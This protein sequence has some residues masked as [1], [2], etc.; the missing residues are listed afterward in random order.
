M[1]QNPGKDLRVK[2]NPENDPPNLGGEVEPGSRGTNL[3][4]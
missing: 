4:N 3:Q 1:N 2:R